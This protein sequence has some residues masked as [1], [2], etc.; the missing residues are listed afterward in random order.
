MNLHAE[1]E[2]LREKYLSVWA[3]VCNIES[4]TSDKLGVDRVGEYFIRL[5]EAQEWEVEIFEQPLAGNVVCITMNPH[6]CL[7]PVTFSGHMDT[8]HPKGMFGYPAVHMDDEKIY[9]PGVV[10]CK[11]GVVAGFLAMEALAKVGFVNRPVRMLL[12]SDEEV[13]SRLSN[14]ATIN[15]ICEKA[16]YSIAFFNLEGHNNGDACL[17]RKGIISFEF[18]VFGQEAHSSACAVR[19]A[20]A[21]LDAAYK[22]FELEK[23]KDDAGLTCNCGVISGG[24]VR[25]TV[26]GK[27]VFTADVRY[28]TQ[29]QYEWICEYAKNLAN[30]VHVAGC[31][32][33][34]E[35]FSGRPAMYRTEKN[36]H[37]FERMNEIY[38]KNGM[39]PLKERNRNA[40]SDAAEITQVGI[41]CVECMGV[42]GGGMHCR[43][44]FA[45]ISSL[46]E[47]AERLASVVLDI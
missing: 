29:E 34:V 11:G 36:L 38:A 10:D 23:I 37:L 8:V 32:C 35:I 44:E 6:A 42:K 5:A 12:Q 16:K 40:G 28:A 13:S 31:K 47:A 3:D 45:F 22:I 17:G 27:C 7:P 25:N 46:T 2:N 20:N 18:T 15:Y 21:I 1:I 19:G 30:T 33:T 24:T 41:P 26:P 4:P 9:G 39:L 43:E 14:K